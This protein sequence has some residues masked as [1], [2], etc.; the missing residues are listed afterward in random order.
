M[1]AQSQERKWEVKEDSMS[2]KRFTVNDQLTQ[3]LYLLYIL[4][5]LS[6][7]PLQAGITYVLPC[8]EAHR[9][10]TEHDSRLLLFLTLENDRPDKCACFFAVLLSTLHFPNIK[11]G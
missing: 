11:L 1:T 9:D 8:S 5:S 7:F 4:H 6:I 10:L 3:Y 2:T